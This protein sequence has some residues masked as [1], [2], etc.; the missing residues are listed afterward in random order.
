MFAEEMLL[1]SYAHICSLA[2]AYCTMSESRKRAA[3]EH[4]SD[5]PNKFVHQYFPESS[6]IG[7]QGL[8]AVIEIKTRALIAREDFKRLR[9]DTWFELPISGANSK[10]AD[11]I[12]TNQ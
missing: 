9:P 10:V 11:N 8:E 7:I 6:I 1:L 5:D 2:V 4:R 12:T 3:F